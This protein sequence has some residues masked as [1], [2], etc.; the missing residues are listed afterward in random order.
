VIRDLA[1]SGKY[2]II[3]G[4]ST[5]GDGIAA[6]MDDFPDIAFVASGSGNGPLGTNG[7]WIDAFG[8]EPAYLAGVAAGL[9][10]ET[11]R[12]GV[13]SNFPFPNTNAPVNSFTA[14]ATSVNPD[15]EITVTFIESWWD[16]AKA[17]ESALAQVSTG[18]DILYGQ[19]FGVIGAAEEAGLLAV[20]DYDDQQYLAPEAVI[21]SNMARWDPA[22]NLVIEAWWDQLANGVPMDGPMERLLFDMADGGSDIA[23]LNEA[24]VPADVQAVVMDLRE[25]ILNRELVIEVNEAPPEF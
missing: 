21:T 3:V 14:G 13:V 7:F 9:M 11:N 17:K 4:H 12:L 1:V 16:P 19:V 15:V 6:V 23:P 10:T 25:Q 24:L 18:V 8:N 5:Y 2:D 22:L 20:G